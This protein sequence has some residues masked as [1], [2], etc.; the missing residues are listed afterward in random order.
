MDLRGGQVFLVPPYCLINVV[1]SLQEGEAEGGQRSD[2]DR[3]WPTSRGSTSLATGVLSFMMG[4]CQGGV[5]R[6][7]GRRQRGFPSLSKSQ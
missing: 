7:P 6:P 1:L 4:Q 3:A 2:P 5:E